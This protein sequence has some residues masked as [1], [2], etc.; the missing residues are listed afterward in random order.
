MPEFETFAFLKYAQFSGPARKVAAACAP[1]AVE[2]YATKT[3]GHTMVRL[4]FV[5]TKNTL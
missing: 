2:G 3:S 4:G 5:A 1:E